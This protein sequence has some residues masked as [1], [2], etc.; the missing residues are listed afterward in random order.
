MLNRL[1]DRVLAG[2]RPGW[3]KRQR[4]APFAA[5]RG[6]V[7]HVVII[8][9]TMSSLATGEETNAGL[10]YK[11]LSEQAGPQLSVY[12]E[13]GIQWTHWNNTMDVLLG[14]G[15]NRQIRRAYGWLASRYRP[16]DRV[17][18]FGYSRGAYAVRSL[19]GV[20]DRVG[21]LRADQATERNVRQAYRHYQA[22]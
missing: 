21:L 20:I 10:I 12:Y 5:R 13:A 6:Q 19:A 17:M 4:N 11:L 2:I 8:D 9:G 1:L 7:L 18:F 16:G 15:I 22:V 3:L 14:R